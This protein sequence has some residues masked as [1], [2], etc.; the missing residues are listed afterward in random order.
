MEECKLANANANGKVHVRVQ[1]THY[2]NDKWIIAYE[3]FA[4]QG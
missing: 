4:I 3:L 1:E 2:C